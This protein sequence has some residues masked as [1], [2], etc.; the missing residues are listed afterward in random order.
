MEDE[1]LRW[2]DRYQTLEEEA[3]RVSAVQRG[4]KVDGGRMFAP[5]RS[6]TDPGRV[7]I[8]FASKHTTLRPFGGE[9][10]LMEEIVCAR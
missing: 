9:K 6:M 10:N 7:V 8:A 3:Y 1:C 4:G 5:T 2:L